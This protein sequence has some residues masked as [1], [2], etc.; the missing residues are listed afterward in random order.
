MIYRP[1]TMYRK[2]YATKYYSSFK[3]QCA[4]MIRTSMVLGADFIFV[5]LIK[6]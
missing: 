5:S 1:S 3:I 2:Q 6:I 4:E